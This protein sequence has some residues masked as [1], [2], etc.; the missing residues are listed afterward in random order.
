MKNSEE[1]LNVGDVIKF[2][3]EDALMRIILIHNKRPD[4]T[5]YNKYALFE[6]DTFMAYSFESYQ[7]L[8]AH[9][10]KYGYE[11]VER[12]NVN[13]QSPMYT[14]YTRDEHIQN[15]PERNQEECQS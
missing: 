12:I 10:N 9:L 3:D 5:L 13:A 4:D 14:Y 15:P 2:K 7:E 8:I 6:Q 1:V 11:I